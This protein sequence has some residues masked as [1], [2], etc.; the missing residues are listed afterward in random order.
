MKEGEVA[1][2]HGFELIEKNPAGVRVVDVTRLYSVD[3]SNLEL[4]RK[5]IATEALPE[6]WRSYFQERLEKLADQS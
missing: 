3:K 1:A 4:L 6:N 5:A 2:G